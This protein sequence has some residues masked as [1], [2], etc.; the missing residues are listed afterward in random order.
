MPVTLSVVNHPETIW[1]ASKVETA[2]QFLEK[3][4][5]RDYRR[6]QRIIRT[7]FSPSLLQENHISPSENG[8]VW[9]AYHAYS[10]HTHLAI[11]PEDV[12]FSI[13]T[14]ISFFINANAG[15]LRS[16]FVAHEGKKELTVF[17]NGDL[18]SANIGA[19]A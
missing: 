17:E 9:S 1:E 11:R 18:E 13:L 10:Q 16:F 3:T 2:E 4:S 19:M 6:C 5:P 7:S 15:K 12:W 14:Q 8:F